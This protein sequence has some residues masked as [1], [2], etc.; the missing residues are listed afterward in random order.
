MSAYSRSRVTG[1]LALV[2]LFTFLPG[3]KGD[4]DGLRATS[5]VSPVSPITPAGMMGIVVVASAMVPTRVNGWTDSVNVT[6]GG[7]GDFT[8]P[9]GDSLGCLNK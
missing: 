1:P 3:F 2:A 7:P 8:R 6:A 9:E 4:S 5:P